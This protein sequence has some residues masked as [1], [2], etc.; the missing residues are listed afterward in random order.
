MDICIEITEKVGNSFG[1]QPLKFC[2]VVRIISRFNR[3]YMML[4]NKEKYL[5]IGMSDSQTEP[6]FQFSAILLCL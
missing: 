2:P 3:G 5:I 4:T 1:T 6:R